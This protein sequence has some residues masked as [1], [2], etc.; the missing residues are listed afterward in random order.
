MA[1]NDANS[2]NDKSEKIKNNTFYPDAIIE[3]EM[4]EM[5][6]ISDSD[7]NI[8]TDESNYTGNDNEGKTNKKDSET[9]DMDKDS[10]GNPIEAI[11]DQVV[12]ETNELI[13]EKKAS[14]N[15]CGCGH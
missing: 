14:H 13:K 6:Y 4:V 7:D 1:T 10:D 2:T 15:G 12:E 3:E 5:V 8:I 9:I 11:D